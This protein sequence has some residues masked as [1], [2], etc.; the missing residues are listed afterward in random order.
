MTKLQNYLSEIADFND[1]MFGSL[2]VSIYD[3]VLQQEYQHLAHHC[4]ASD[5]KVLLH[6]SVSYFLIAPFF[7]LLNLPGFLLSAY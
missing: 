7:F 5:V 6:F 4:S 2:H 1:F 3:R